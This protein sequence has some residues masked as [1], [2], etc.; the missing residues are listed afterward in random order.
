MH[1]II[2]NC[3]HGDLSGVVE[4]AKYEGTTPEALSRNIIAGRTILLKN[5]AREIGRAHV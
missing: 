3:L 5:K 2:E 4:A 1:S